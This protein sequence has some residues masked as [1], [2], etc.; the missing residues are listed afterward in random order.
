MPRDVNLEELHSAQGL[1]LMHQGPPLS[2]GPLPSLFY[3]ALSA[4]DSLTLD[5]FNQPVQ[6]LSDIP[7]IRIFSITLPSHGPGFDNNLAMGLWADAV[8]GGSDPITPFINRCRAE[9]NRLIDQGYIDPAHLAAAGLSRGGFIATRLAARDARIRTL[10]AYAPLV[11]LADLSEFK[12]LQESPLTLSLKLENLIPKLIDKQIRIYCGNRD[13]RVNTDKI[14]HFV[15]AVAEGSFTN[16][17]RSPSVELMLS[18]SVGHQG[19]GTPPHIFKS[20]VEWLREKL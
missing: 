13:T 2:T 4:Q 20:G 17:K 6:F 5:P 10:L 8:A 18:P 12:D 19:H 9:I 11:D 7:A 15:R 1:T 16:G 14:Y 3:F